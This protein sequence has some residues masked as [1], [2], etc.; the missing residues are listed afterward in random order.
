MAC[1]EHWNNRDH[2]PEMKE[3]RCP[4]LDVAG[5]QSYFP[6]KDS[7]RMSEVLPKGEFVMVPDAGHELH[8]DNPGAWRSAVEKFILKTNGQL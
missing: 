3:V 1:R 5:E 8:F 2:T 4:T 7:R 6:A